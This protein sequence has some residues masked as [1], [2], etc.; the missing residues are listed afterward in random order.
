MRPAPS[1]SGR[2]RPVTQPARH[3]RQTMITHVLLLT[4]W[5]KSIEMERYSRQ[6]RFH[7]LGEAGQQ[8]IRQASVAIAGCGALGSVQ[9]EILTRAGIGRLRLID[10]DF[11]ELSN[12][13]RQFLF[14][15][16][17]A[18]DSVPKAVAAAR[19]LARINS[20]VT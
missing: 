5:W 13:Q 6:T 14:D 15:Q 10:R 20:E 9:A 3:A 2:G 4:S 17:D 7:P 18:R 1:R 19:R 11:V 8:R 16:S 12:L